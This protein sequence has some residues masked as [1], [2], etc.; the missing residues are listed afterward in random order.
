[1][2]ISLSAD[3]P[4][5]FYVSM[6]SCWSSKPSVVLHGGPNLSSPPI[7]AADFHS[8]SSTVD[9]VLGNEKHT[10]IK[11]GTF[12]SS[13]VFDV[14]IRSTDKNERFEWK[15][16][17]GAEVA[18]LE[19]QRR[20]MKLVRVSTGAVVAAWTRPNIGMKKK[21]KLRFLVR[22]SIPESYK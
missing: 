8:F 2:R 9:I 5:I 7:A 16:S 12:S 10:L 21:G 22:W 20:G 1:M 14:H 18:S 19:G 13:Q 11:S 3:S 15:A 6:H 17:T 4:T